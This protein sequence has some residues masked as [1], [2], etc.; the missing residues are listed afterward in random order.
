M[1]VF[2]TG[3]NGFIG[4]AVARAFAR[5]GYE[6]IGL[7]RDQ[8]KGQALAAAEVRPAIGSLEDA[9][10]LVDAARDCQVIVHAAAEASPRMFE[11]DRL[12]ITTLLSCAS[13]SRLPRKFLYTSGVWVY[14]DTRECAVT[15]GSPLA[16]PALVT[17]RVDSERLVLAASSAMLHTLV[18]RPGCVYGGSG[19]LTAAWFEH[20]RASGA[21][22]IVGTG[23][24][25]W[26]MVHVEDLADLYV[27]AAES[28]ES[29]EVFNA[30]DRSRFTVMEC[31][32]AASHA[33]GGAGRVE[34]LPAADARAR[35]G[36][37]ADCLALNQHVDSRKAVRLLGW[38]PRHGGFADGAGRYFLAWQA[39][40]RSQ[41]AGRQA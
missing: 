11:L 6:V 14:G 39:S 8:R 10:S 13:E 27:R 16:P 21:A 41:P 20:A 32:R 34:A 30:T 28:S 15:E 12:A 37:L 24:N 22:R 35:M 7:V 23:E 1:K 38:Q 9:S 26:A 2:V 4:S 31:A 36:A 3:A 25:R 19:S 33:A 18:I 29:G 17:Q 5:A 40:R